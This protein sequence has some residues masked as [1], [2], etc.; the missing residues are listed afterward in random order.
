MDWK[1]FLSETRENYKLLNEEIPETFRGFSVMGE[2]AK[3]NG[4]VDNKTKEFVALGIAISTRC[5]SCIGMHIEALI[6][7]GTN[8]DEL[9]EILAMCSFMGGGPSIT[10]SS[11]ALEAYDQLSS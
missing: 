7:L 8:R 2:E 6:K 9:V 11:K 4:L 5:E 10:F 1:K 3:K